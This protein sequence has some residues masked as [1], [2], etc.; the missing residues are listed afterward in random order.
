MKHITKILMALVIALAFVGAASA[1]VLPGQTPETQTI[2][3]STVVQC[4]GITMSQENY[5][6]QLTTATLNGAPLESKEIYGQSTYNNQIVGVGQTTYVKNI[7]LNTQNQVATGTNV[8]TSQIVDFNGAMIVGDESASIF[9]AGMA[10]SAK[11]AFLCPFTAA[12]ETNVPPFNENVVMGSHFDATVIKQNSQV[13]ILGV[14]KTGDVPSTLNYNFGATGQGSVN[15]YMDVLAQDGRG[16]GQTLIS[17]EIKTVIPAVKDKCGKVV[18]PEKTVITP[19]KY[20]PI[21]PSGQIQY[22]KRHQQWEPSC[23]ERT[24]S[25]FQRLQRNPT[26]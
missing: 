16:T 11:D 18:T 23:S 5:V 10:T 3:T 6:S 21:T 17:K 15:T 7:D 22:Q 24:C 1:A 4:D 20:T 14:A 8:K 13:G 19:A 2:S 25:M 26:T 9:N 12:T